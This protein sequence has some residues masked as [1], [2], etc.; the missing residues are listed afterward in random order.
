M[1]ASASRKPL[2]SW[3]VMA[4]II[5]SYGAFLATH[6]GVLAALGIDTLGD[7]FMDFFAILASADA[8]AQGRD[9]YAINRLDPLGR[10]HMYSHWWL[11]VHHL[12]LTRSDS[13]AVGLVIVF[14]TVAALVV[15]LRPVN[16]GEAVWYAAVV[17]APPLV[18]GYQRANNDLVVFLILLPV[19]SLLSRGRSLAS[20]LAVALIALAAGLKFYPAA[21]LLVIL[22]VDRRTFRWLCPLGIVLVGLALLDV[23]S[24]YP[25]VL[26]YMPKAEGPLTFQSRT[27]LDA[28]HLSPGVGYAA[29]ALTAAG[30]MIVLRRS[31][32]FDRWSVPAERRGAWLAFVLGAS[33]LCACFVVGTNYGY[34]FIYAVLLAP[35]LWK[36]ARDASLGEGL[37]GFAR[38]TAGMLL[39][40]LWADGLYLVFLQS[41][42]GTEP[43]ERLQW[44]SERF[45]LCEQPLHWALVICL[46]G[47]LVVFVRDAVL[48]LRV[49]APAARQSA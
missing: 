7:W 45:T 48:S 4:G 6:A 42:V 39:F 34:R 10:P 16:A 44:L 3:L 35:F 2:A 18:L 5:L 31:R 46:T 28:L 19:A 14:A 23:A 15:F 43:L 12:G 49:S 32:L 9:P 20:V 47:F 1:N 29:G 21:A 25:K 36:T 24:D 17:C 37:R 40:S 11:Y 30:W 13:M 22:S 27:L 8:Y 26:R 33:V 38:I 41:R